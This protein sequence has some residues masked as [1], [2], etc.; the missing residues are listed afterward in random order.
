MVRSLSGI[1]LNFGFT[2]QM[3]RRWTQ[4][5]ADVVDELWICVRE[6]SIDDELTNN[7][8]STLL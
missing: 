2:T 7:E 5:N 1:D 4:I 6:R 8:P 3:H